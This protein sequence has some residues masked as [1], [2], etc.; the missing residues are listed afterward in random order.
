[1]QLL[2]SRNMDLYLSRIL[3]R[4]GKFVPLFSVCHGSFQPATNNGHLENEEALLLI[5]VLYLMYLLHIDAV[6]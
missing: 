1:M 4:A 2:Y 3:C 6:F 5:A